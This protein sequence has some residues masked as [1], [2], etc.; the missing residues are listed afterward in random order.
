M[1]YER[2]G[3]GDVQRAVAELT[4]RLPEPLHP[5]ARLAYN[6]W[7]SW[8]PGG[9]DVFAA[10][11][12]PR[13]AATND[14]PIR[15]LRDLTSSQLEQ[16]ADGRAPRRRHRRARRRVRPI[17]AGR[18]PRRTRLRS[19]APSSRCTRRSRSTRAGSVSSPATSSRRHP[20][21][22]CRASVSASVTG[23]GTSTNASIPPATSTST[24]PRSIPSRCLRCSSRTPARRSR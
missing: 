3:A 23:A 12:G 17:H 9:R 22:T 18:A 16:A 20:T 15:F 19:S 11:D 21:A 1:S 5:L 24:G 2:P 10:I 13:F 14:N 8:A 6:Y 4:S 7:W